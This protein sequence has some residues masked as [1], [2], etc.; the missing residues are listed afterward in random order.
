MGALQTR[1]GSM[2][3]GKGK[4]IAQA[5]SLSEEEWESLQ[6]GGLQ[7]E[8]Q[9]QVQLASGLGQAGPR[10]LYLGKARDS[11]YRWPHLWEAG[12][13]PSSLVPPLCIFRLGPDRK[14]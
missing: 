14:R 5:A 4:S 11:W 6:E 3:S 9:G 10:V 12:S 1:W 7:T 2:V 13:W 8:G